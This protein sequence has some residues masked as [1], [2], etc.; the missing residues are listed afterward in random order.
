[1]FKLYV[2]FIIIFYALISFASLAEDKIIYKNY[3]F[4]E[5]Y[6]KLHY[7]PGYYFGG[8]PEEISDLETYISKD[9]SWY[10][11]INSYLRNFPKTNYE[12]Y[13]ISPDRAKSM[14]KNIDKII[15]LT[16]ALPE[17]LILFRGVDLK[18]RGSKSFLEG[19][20]FIE[21][22]YA[23]TSTSFKVA[24]YFATKISESNSKKAIF[25]FYSSKKDLKGFL[26]DRDEDEVLLSRNLKIK[27]MTIIK[28]SNYDLNIAQICDVKCEKK[29]PN[30]V[31]KYLTLG[32]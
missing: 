31:G 9:D 11:E 32:N 12:W 10:K 13:S 1:M 7:E 6:S 15:S 22:G 25:V 28:K 23:S 16:P 3:Q 20:T 19:E 26:I 27:V 4:S 21:K 24:E 2:F 17:D 30:I 18:Y 29:L 5:L 8:S 14:V